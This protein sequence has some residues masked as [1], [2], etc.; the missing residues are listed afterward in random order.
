MITVKIIPPKAKVRLKAL[1]CNGTVNFVK[2]DLD[3]EPIYNVCFFTDGQQRFCDV[4]AD[5]VE[6]I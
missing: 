4:F 6:A 2:I 1:D 3:N 5:E